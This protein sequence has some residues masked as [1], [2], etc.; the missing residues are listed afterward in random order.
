[1]VWWIWVLVGLAL[2]AVEVVTPG[3]IIMLFFGAAALFVGAL[4]VLGLGGPVWFQWALFSV[5][6]VASLLTLRGPI[7]RKMKAG[8]D[9]PDQI[10]SLLGNTVVVAQDL[11]PGAQGK[12]ELRGTSWTVQ[13]VGDK[14]LTRGQT[15]DVEKVEALKLF[16]R[17]IGT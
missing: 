17:E 7:L 10:D 6:S 13:N 3:G 8:S 9:H 11:A 5:L 1:M 15:C 2:V 4:V 16:V 12:A 14:S